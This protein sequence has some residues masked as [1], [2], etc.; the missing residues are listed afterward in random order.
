MGGFKKGGLNFDAKVRRASYRPDDIFYAHIA[1]MDS[2]AKGL[3]AAHRIIEDGIL[4]DF[5]SKKY[6]SYSSGIGKKISEKNTN[7]K[8]LEKYALGLETIDNPSGRQ[9]YLESILNEYIMGA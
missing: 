4:K 9:E 7:F 3:K 8:S 6:E 5:I 2:F 1:G